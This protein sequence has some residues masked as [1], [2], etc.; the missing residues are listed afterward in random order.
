M[1]ADWSGF[2][3]NVSDKL[4]SQSIKDNQDLAQFIADQY[5]NATVGK[6]QS[7][8]GNTHREGVRQ[9]LVSGFKKGFDELQKN[10][11]PTFQQKEKDPMYEDLKEDL[12]STK[13]SDFNTETEY[14]K[15]AETNQTAPT[16]KF[17]QFF[18]DFSKYPKTADEAAPEIAKRLIL[19]YDGSAKFLRWLKTLPNGMFGSVGKKVYDEFL[20]LAKA[21][22]NLKVGDSAEGVTVDGDVVSGK[23]AKVVQT[24]NAYI[25]YISYKGAKG[26]YITKEIKDGT[27]TIPVNLDQIKVKKEG[28][29]L[30]T[31]IFQMEHSDAPDKIPDYLTP[32]F[33]AKFTYDPNIDVNFGIPNIISIFDN[34]VNG[35]IAL[36]VKIYGD[37]KGGEKK[38]YLD[39]LQRW[40]QSQADEAKKNEDPNAPEPTDPYEIMAKAV[41]DYWKSAL[42]QPLSSTPPVPPCTLTT[43]LGGTYLPVY[44]GNQKS[45]ANFLRRAWNSGKLLKVPGLE[46]PASKLVATALAV[47]FA[48]HLLELKFVYQGGIPSP[49][50]PVPMLGFVPVVF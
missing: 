36:K 44:Y 50:G 18:E 8:F 13:A 43:P 41:I 30:Y 17:F 4:A 40:I 45:L 42:V 22:V 21:P 49:S 12:P 5:C 33:I 48:K 1:P 11:E 31:R 15:W 7:P 37:T 16:F 9:L 6:A 46:K 29:K 19:Q 24:G 35:K 27:I 32:K 28:I 25:Y 20:K 3:T 10:P 23:I 14:L 38:R 26:N 2:V 47:S 39:S 34:L